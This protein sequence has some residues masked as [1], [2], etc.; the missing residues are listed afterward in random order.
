VR[1]KHPESAR[2]KDSF[3]V[4]DVWETIERHAA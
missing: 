4:I 1:P 2:A 3:D